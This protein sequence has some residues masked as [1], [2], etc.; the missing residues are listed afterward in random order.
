MIGT[1]C[2]GLSDELRDKYSIWE[3]P[4]KQTVYDILEKELLA[5]F[6]GE[7]AF[8]PGLILW[9]SCCTILCSI[10]PLR[11]IL[12]SVA[13]LLASTFFQGIHDRNHMLWIIG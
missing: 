5:S 3:L 10:E 2:S 13:S 1:T 12:G 6:F 7:H 11:R 4:R 8:T 9:G